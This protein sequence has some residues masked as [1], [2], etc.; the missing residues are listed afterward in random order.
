MCLSIRYVNMPPPP[1]PPHYLTHSLSLTVSVSLSHYLSMSI[2]LTHYLTLHHFVN[3]TIWGASAV[4]SSIAVSLPVTNAISLT[5]SI[6]LSLTIR[7]F[8]VLRLSVPWSSWLLVFLPLLYSN[9]RAPMC[10]WYLVHSKCIHLLGIVHHLSLDGSF[11]LLL[12]FPCGFRFMP[13]LYLIRC[14]N[15]NSIITTISSLTWSWFIDLSI[16]SISSQILCGFFWRGYHWLRCTDLLCHCQD[17]TVCLPY[18]QRTMGVFY[19]SCVAV[20]CVMD[21]VSGRHHPLMT[22]PS[23]DTTLWWHHPFI[24]THLSYLLIS[25]T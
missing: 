11:E 6:T 2:Y 7:R 19:W 3:Q 1:P 16:S 10:W 23:D 5:F 21:D 9:D 8:G 15:S 22:P 25:L 14:H 24:C 12:F 4:Y 18:L 20:L 17:L 13:F